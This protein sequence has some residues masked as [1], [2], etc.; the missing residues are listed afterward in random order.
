M[1]IKH[2][3]QTSKPDDPNYDVSADEWNEDHTI[4]GDVDFDNNESLKHR[5][6]NVTDLPTPDTGMLGR[7]AYKT[8]D[9][10]LYIV[11]PA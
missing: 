10:H 6:E 4:D 9:K 8:G 11:I 5:V 1:G 2:A 3:T 7:L